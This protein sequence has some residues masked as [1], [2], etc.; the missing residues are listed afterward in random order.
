[1]FIKQTCDPHLPF[2]HHPQP[3]LQKHHQILRNEEQPCHLN[4]KVKDHYIHSNMLQ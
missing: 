2:C 4:D 3:R 1:M